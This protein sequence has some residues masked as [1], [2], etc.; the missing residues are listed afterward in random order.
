MKS[1]D[2]PLGLL[3]LSLGLHYHHHHDHHSLS[4]SFP[5]SPSS[6]KLH[7]FLSCRR[8]VLKLCSVCMYIH[9]YCIW[10]SPVAQMVKNLPAMQETWARSLGREDPLEKKMAI[11][12]SILAWRIP[13]TEDPGGLQSIGLQRVWHNWVTNTHTHILYTHTYTHTHIQYFNMQAE[14]DLWDHQV[15]KQWTLADPRLR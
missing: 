12:S 2:Q 9:T 13:W 8:I 14:R 6:S 15:V 1:Q 7:F 5:S 10:A 11:H 3:I 4:L